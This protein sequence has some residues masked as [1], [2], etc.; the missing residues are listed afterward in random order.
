[1]A[2]NEQRTLGVNAVN[3]MVRFDLGNGEWVDLTPE[4]ANKFAALTV[5]AVQEAVYGNRP[6]TLTITFN[7]EN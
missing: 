1:M 3:G 6:K 5:R 2:A 7:F 4:Q